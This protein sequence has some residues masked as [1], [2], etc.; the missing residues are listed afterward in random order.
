[1]D[2]KGTRKQAAEQV[3]GNRDHGWY[4]EEMN[5]LLYSLSEHFLSDIFYQPKRNIVSIYSRTE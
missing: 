5:P 2:G 1:M 4:S 3:P